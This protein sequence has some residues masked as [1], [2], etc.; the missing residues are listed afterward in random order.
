MKAKAIIWS[1]LSYLCRVRMTVARSRAGAALTSDFISSKLSI[2][3]FWSNKIYYTS[4]LLLL[5]RSICVVSVVT[6]Q[7]PIHTFV[8]IVCRPCRSSRN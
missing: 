1:R 5:V 7:Q 8:G 2:D 4:S 3:C 6:Q